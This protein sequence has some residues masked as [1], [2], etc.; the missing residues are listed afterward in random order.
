MSELID[1][2]DQVFI[3]DEAT[4]MVTV[5]ASADRRALD[6]VVIASGL[7]NGASLISHIVVV[8]PFISIDWLTTMATLILGFTR[9]DDLWGDVDIGPS[10]LP[11]NLDS[12]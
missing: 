3:W 9:N 12:I 4:L 10:S 2:V 1:S 7:I 11:R 6:A 8:H 5:F